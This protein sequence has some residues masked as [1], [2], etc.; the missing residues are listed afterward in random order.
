M[1]LIMVPSRLLNGTDRPYAFRIRSSGRID[2]MSFRMPSARSRRWGSWAGALVLLLSLFTGSPAQG[3]DL[4]TEFEEKVTTFSLSNGLTF[5][6][7]ERHDAPVVSFHTYADVG[8][9][10]EPAGRTGLAHMFEHMA[11]K[12]TTTIGT[13]DIEN[14]LRAMGELED[15]YLQLRQEQAKGPQA[16]SA[17]IATLE[18]QFEEAQEEAESYINEGEYENILEREGVTRMNAY[19]SPDATAYM[20]SLPANK[21]ELFFA[22]ESDR[23]HNPVL[24][25]FYTERDVVMEERR[26]S[27]SSPVGRLIEAFVTTAF[28]AHPYGQPTI[29]HMSDLR[30][31]SRSDAEAFFEKY[32][33]ANNLTI[34]IAGDVDP[35]RV[36]ELAE[37]YFERLP[38]K[39]TPLPVMTEEPEQLGQRRVIIEEETQPYVAI[40]YHRGSMQSENAPVYSVLSDV[41][42]E[43]RTSRLHKRLVEREKALN[44]QA[45]PSFPGEKYP[46]LF[47]FFGLP[48]QGIPPDSIEQAIYDELDTIKNEGITQEELERAKTRTR[49]ELVGNLDS[50]PGLAN[51]FARMQALTGDWRNIFHRLEEVGAVTVDDVQRVAEEMFD[52][53]NR[54][55]AMIKTTEEADP[56]TTAAAN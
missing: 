24:R 17:R 35:E 12:G 38:Q 28:K 55:V 10:N 21:L 34:G 2:F 9:I 37:E 30:T 42:T 3:Q 8:S 39:E 5:V 44:I 29:G 56:N 26:G 27:E 32:Y 25:E 49:A 14:E 51:Q 53:S 23:F 52:R 48:N 41:L 13:E 36:K 4:L 31:L 16:D 43:G 33:G 45:V 50:N 40:G 6:V 20:Y 18:Q 19:T 47:V 46:N 22:M 11:F 7:I 1:V 54:T 15:I